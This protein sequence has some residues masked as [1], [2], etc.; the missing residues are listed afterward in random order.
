MCAAEGSGVITGVRS[1]KG[2]SLIEMCVM[3][4]ILSLIAAPLAVIYKNYIE[5]YKINETVGTQVDVQDAINI[6]FATNGRYPRPARID[7]VE[8]DA[9]FGE[10]GTATP[11]A[12]SSASWVTTDGI[13]V[14]DDSANEILI[15]A[16]PLDALGLG[17]DDGLDYWGNKILYAVTRLQTDATT[18]NPAG[19]RV[20]VQILDPAQPPD[21]RTPINLPDTYDMVLVS[22]GETAKGHYSAASALVDVCVGPVNEFED[23]NCDFDSVFLLDKNPDDISNSTVSSAVNDRFYDDMTLSQLSIPSESWY[24]AETDPNYAISQATRVGVQTTDPQDRVHVMGDVQAEEDVMSDQICN[25]DQT[26]CFNP[27]IIAGN[28]DDMDCRFD[29]VAPGDKPVLGIGNSRVGCANG[30][31]G[32]GTPLDGSTPPYRFD[33]SLFQ[34][35]NCAASGQ[36]MRG[37]NGSGAPLCGTP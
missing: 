15:G 36:L 17:V 20:A 13:C 30:V 12:C 33:M 11:V 23:E 2:F 6:F 8:G 1:Q 32:S 16:V 18:Y 29:S 22:G 34:A 4:I 7:L 5:Q 3:L 26:V 28:V 35:G 19:G 9:N 21:V 27:E 24:E 25:E 37:I 31:D 14:T 10:E